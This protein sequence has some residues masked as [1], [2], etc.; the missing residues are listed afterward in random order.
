MRNDFKQMYIMNAL[1]ICLNN[2][3][4]FR[5]CISN[6]KQLCNFWCCCWY[7]LCCSIMLHIISTGECESVLSACLFESTWNPFTFTPP[8]PPLPSICIREFYMSYHRL[9]DI[10][11]VL[12]QF[13]NLRKVFYKR[14]GKK[15]NLYVPSY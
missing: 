9:T 14:L 11:L 10:C 12:C 7:S 8:H 15:P 3:Y 13:I 1:D 6:S 4:M 5:C 2:H